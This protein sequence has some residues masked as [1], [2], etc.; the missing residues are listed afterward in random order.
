MLHLDTERLAALADGEPT[1]VE[2]DHLRDC[3]VCTGERDAYRRLL[4]LAAAER[5]QL[6]PPLTEWDR[7]AAHLRHEGGLRGAGGRRISRW[8][9]RVAASLALVAGGTALGRVS[10]GAALVPGLGEN[11]MVAVGGSDSTPEFQSTSDAL[12]AMSEAEYRYQAASAFVAAHDTSTLRETSSDSSLL[13]RSR[14]AA[15][16]NVA[17]ATREALYEAPHDPLINRYYLTTLGAREATIQRLGM[18][19]PV[20]MKISRY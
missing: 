15:L 6:A 16:D 1:A 20:G 10:A 4:L 5:Q 12:A 7:I 3:A 11:R 2:L 14:L 8:G 19:L 13:Y 9:L 17:A 18:A